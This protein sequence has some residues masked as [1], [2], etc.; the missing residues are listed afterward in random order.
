MWDSLQRRWILL[1]WMTLLLEVWK[2]HTS[3]MKM[4]FNL[5]NSLHFFIKLLVATINSSTT[6]SKETLLIVVVVLILLNKCKR[7]MSNV[8]ENIFSCIFHCHISAMCCKISRLQDTFHHQGCC[9]QHLHIFQTI[10]GRREILDLSF[11]KGWYRLR[12]LL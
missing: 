10:Q 12:I 7:K 4:I 2:T 5:L 11:L 6:H 3:R 8:H 9:H 1:W